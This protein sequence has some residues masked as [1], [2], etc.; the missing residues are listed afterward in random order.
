MSPRFAITLLGGFGARRDDILIDLP[1]G[2]QRVVALVALARRPVDREWVCTTL[3]PAVPMGSAIA[4]LRSALWRLR[5]YG[6]E[7]MLATGRRTLAIA[8]GVDVDWWRVADL[9]SQV[10]SDFVCTGPPDPVL[11]AEFVAFLHAGELLDGWSDEW[12]VGDRGPYHAMRWLTLARLASRSPDT[13]DRSDASE[14]VG[15]AVCADPL[16]EL[17][18]TAAAMV[19]AV[20]GPGR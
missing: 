8:P 15:Y 2:C 18:E 1:P 3:W 12:A 14:L 19:P 13:G 20:I 9:S 7:D 11:S 17:Q 5:C 16:Q 4:R 6:A 10:F